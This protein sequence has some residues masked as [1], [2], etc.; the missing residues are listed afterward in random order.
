MLFV[1]GWALDSGDTTVKQ[2]TVQEL[3]DDLGNDGAQMARLGGKALFVNVGVALKMLV[4]N[5]LERIFLGESGALDSVCLPYGPH[6][7]GQFV[8]KPA[9]IRIE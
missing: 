6:S 8:M 2:T 4:E 5:S 3:F 9:I 1:V 7:L